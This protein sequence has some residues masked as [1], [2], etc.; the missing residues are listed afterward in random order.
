[1]KKH[2]DEY[3]DEAAVLRQDRTAIIGCTSLFGWMLLGGVFMLL[4]PLFTPM[5]RRSAVISVIIGAV[6][7]SVSGIV[8]FLILQ[9][10]HNKTVITSAGISFFTGKAQKELFISWDDME[11]VCYT[12]SLYY[13]HA[14]YYHIR[15]KNTGRGY[16]ISIDPAHEEQIRKFVPQERFT[17]GGSY[18][19]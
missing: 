7:C 10:R 12:R 11:Q 6:L 9:G 16:T 3:T 17:K 18:Y 8:I 4:S 19:S 15:M 2:R 13:G 5:E 14:T 1:M